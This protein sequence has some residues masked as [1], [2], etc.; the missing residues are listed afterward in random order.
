MMA[1][2]AGPLVTVALLPLLLAGCAAGEIASQR[3]DATAEELRQASIEQ[4]QCRAA[5]FDK[6][7]YARITPHLAVVAEAATPE[8]LADPTRVSAGERSL[9]TAMFAEA[10]LCRR[11]TMKRVATLVPELAPVM[12]EHETE[13]D[14]NRERLLAGGITWGEAN[15]RSA[16]LAAGFRTRSQEAMRANQARVV[17]E[18][19]AEE[20][21]QVALTL[22]EAFIAG[23]VA[24]LTGVYIAPPSR[25]VTVRTVRVVPVPVRR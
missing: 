3:L 17:T 12:V 14:R 2:L 9:V 1:R 11:T 22:V 5:A 16:S 13:G 20:R 19:E 7:E 15:A 10:A 24:G 21:R 4:R 25:T 6:P 18:A 23:T 8:Q